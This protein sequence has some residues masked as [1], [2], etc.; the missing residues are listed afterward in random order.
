MPLI[1]GRKVEHQPV[2]SEATGT[3]T[4]II[5]AVIAALMMESSMANHP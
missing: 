5:E 4:K 3:G 1:S 2:W